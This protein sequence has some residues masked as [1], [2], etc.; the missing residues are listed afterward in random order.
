MGAKA[1]RLHKEMEKYAGCFSISNSFFIY[2]DNLLGLF[3]FAHKNT[4]LSMQ[5][6]QIAEP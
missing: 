6:K 1:Q 4:L 3:A 5:P 2:N